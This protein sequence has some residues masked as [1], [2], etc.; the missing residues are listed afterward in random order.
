MISEQSKI[1]CERYQ[2]VLEKMD[3]A[4]LRVGRKGSDIKL[5]VVT[6]TQS[7]DKVKS[8]YDC[9]IRK[10]GENYPEESLEKINYFRGN[11][12]IEWHMIGHLQSRKARLIPGNFHRIHSIDS[13]SVALKLEQLLTE[14]S[15][16][17]AGLLEFNIA[18]EGSKSGWDAS[19]LSVWPQLVDQILPILEFTH[20]KIDGIMVMPP[21]S[22]DEKIT[23]I[24]FQKAVSLAGFIRSQ[25]NRTDFCQLSMGTSSDYE[26]AVE[27]GATFIRVGTAIMGERERK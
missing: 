4:A 14:N 20:L 3:Q 24:Y 21:L 25:T 10:F 11:E 26:I 6:K 23:R 1:I 27:E 16:A 22:F 18:G 13:V 19:N 9:G 17:L 12:N 15:Q 8:A 7:L 5:I 2:T